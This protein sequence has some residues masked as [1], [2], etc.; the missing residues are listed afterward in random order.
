VDEADRK[1]AREVWRQAIAS[2]QPFELECHLA[3]RPD[4]GTRWHLVRGVIQY[5]ETSA[6][7]GWIVSGADIEELKQANRAK[8][9]FL[10]IASHELRG[11]LSVVLA[12]TEPALSTG[13]RP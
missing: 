11:P 2:G 3:R 10:A 1:S 5:D 4:G 6:P 7:S 8:D 12:Q 13:Q 9:A